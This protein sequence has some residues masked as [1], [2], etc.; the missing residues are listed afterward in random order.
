[1]ISL[2]VAGRTFTDAPTRSGHIL[3]SLG[4][5]FDG[6]PVRGEDI[7]RPAGH[8]S[9]GL[10]AY[11]GARLIDASV[12]VLTDD[13]ASAGEAQR[14][15]SGLLADGGFSDLTITD[16]SGMALT[17]RV[18][19]GGQPLV[20]WAP[21]SS[22]IRASLQF[23]A[24]DPLRYGDP[25][26]IPTP[27]PVRRGG[28]RFP[29][30]S[31]GHGRNVGALDFGPPSLTGRIVLSNPGTADTWPQFQVEG[32]V[33]SA[34]FEI[35]VVGTDRRIRFSGPV[36]AGSVLLIDSASGTAVIDGDADRGGQ[37]T[38]RDWFPIPAGGSVEIAFI[39]LGP[40]SEAVLT[41]VVR[42]GWW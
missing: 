12:S 25:V 6:P 4:G 16:P 33:S 26:G 24:P 36:A 7:S 31:D 32:P 13:P 20:S 9:F 42:P 3:E 30:F 5:W 38:Y 40:T 37:L 35:A 29:L 23:W 10:S 39:P 41:G 8:G 2:E 22:A 21:Q 1:M 11:R 28:L 14:W 19:L 34:G 27:F 15:L 17:S 18:R